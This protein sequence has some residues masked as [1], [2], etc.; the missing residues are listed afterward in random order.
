MLPTLIYSLHID[1][2]KPRRT[3]ELDA[4][5]F[6]MVNSMQDEIHG[7]LAGAGG[8]VPYYAMARHMD[9]HNT[10]QGPCWDHRLQWLGLYLQFIRLYIYMALHGPWLCC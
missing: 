9:R 4:Q 7:S 10:G 2:M 1:V 3:D 8:V 6:T 5:L